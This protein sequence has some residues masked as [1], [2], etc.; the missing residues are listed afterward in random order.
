[1]T[2]SSSTGLLLDTHIWLRYLG[3]SG[4]LSKSALP[5]IH[6]AGANGSLFV[7]VIS[8][9]ELAM[10][11]K[12]GRVSLHTSVGRWT[13]EALAKPGINLLPFTPEIAIESVNLPEPI[14]KDPSDRIL[15]ASARVERLTLVTRDDA[16]LDFAVRT[17]LA[18]L[19]A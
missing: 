12:R 8:I 19:R 7:S 6:R 5:A 13:E 11:A 1:L 17:Q 3:I 16:V 15:I 9:W 2:K 14:H 10:L 4:E 18:H